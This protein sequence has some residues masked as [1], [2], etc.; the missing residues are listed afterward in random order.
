MLS[1]LAAVSI[2]P[3]IACP[4]FSTYPSGNLRVCHRLGSKKTLEGQEKIQDLDPRFEG[5]TEGAGSAKL[6]PS[7]QEEHGPPSR[8]DASKNGTRK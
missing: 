8:T 6:L 5:C 1:E 4:S 2:S 3:T 7:F